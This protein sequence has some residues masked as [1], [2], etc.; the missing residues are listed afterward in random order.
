MTTLMK[1][2]AFLTS[3]IVAVAL[4]RGVAAQGPKLASIGWITAQRASSLT[5]FVAAFRASLANM[6]YVEGRN[7]TIAFR[8]GDDAIERVPELATDLM[9]LPVSLLVAQ[10]AAVDVL[11]RLDLKVPIVYVYSGDPVTAGF[12][13][14]L[15][16]PR[17][18]MTGL[19]FM[20]PEFNGKRLEILR[21]IIPDLRRVAVIA[22]PEHPG[23]HIERGYTEA[24]AHTL[25]VTID[26]FPT[27][28]R[29]ELDSAFTAMAENLPQGISV[30]ADGFAI[31]NRD[32]IIEFAMRYRLPVIS[33]W[34]VFARS[35]AICTYGPALI[36][37]YRRLAEYV[38][39][40]LKG[41]KPADL[42]IEQPTQFELVINQRTA[43]ALGLAIPQSLM[44]RADEVIE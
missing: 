14:S 21:E 9:R 1:R 32:R 42:P 11:S 13:E 29:D 20:A 12:A 43:K 10:G 16:R 7:L 15:A 3:A 44:V 35:G 24:A 31:Q 18:N 2:R 5:P 33:G 38:D 19:T 36:A 23:Q 30:F 41:A 34:A 26:Y 6:G 17:K 25:G 4:P 22:N 39:R 27:R 37:S 40:I 8:Y 28:S